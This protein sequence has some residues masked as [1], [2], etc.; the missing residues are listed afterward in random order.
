MQAL[1]IVAD[2][3]ATVSSAVDKIR[4]LNHKNKACLFLPVVPVVDQR[5]M[6]NPSVS[7]TDQCF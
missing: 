6:V 2:E 3:R 4:I 7:D 1:Q 5:F